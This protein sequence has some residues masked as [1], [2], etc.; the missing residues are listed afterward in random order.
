LAAGAPLDT[1]EES[2]VRRRPAKPPSRPG[3]VAG[4]A[5]VPG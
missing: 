2:E 5:R 3:G 4:R 1:D